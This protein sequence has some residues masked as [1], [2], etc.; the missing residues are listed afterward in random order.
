MKWLDDVSY[1]L[2]IGAALLMA[3]MPIQP[4]P[5]LVEKYHLW[6]QG[7]LHR[8]VDIFDVCWHLLPTILLI[9]KLLRAY[10]R[11]KGI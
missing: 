4:E 9:I 11:N 6:K 5:H 7:E 8:W 3:W 1:V 10:S 2:L